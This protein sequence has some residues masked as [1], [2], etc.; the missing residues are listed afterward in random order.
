MSAPDINA[1]VIVLAAGDS[2]RMGM[3]KA[4]L[5]WHG[6]PLIKHVL[7]T[8]RAGGCSDAFVVLGKD[9]DTIRA[10]GLLEGVNGIVNPDPSQGQISSLKLAMRSLDFSTDCCVVWPVDCPL[11]QAADVRALIAAYAQ[12]RA[13]LMRIFMP[14]HGGKRGHPMLVDIGF[15]QPFMELKPGQSARAVIDANP[16]QVKEVPTE[17]PGVL[18]DVD[19][20]EEYATALKSRL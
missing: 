18:V 11:V 13:S 6:T 19:T 20:P 9:A 12:W 2:T 15:R 8:A 3:P 16:T 1:A 5:D 10:G 14:V 17:N 4:L 7:D